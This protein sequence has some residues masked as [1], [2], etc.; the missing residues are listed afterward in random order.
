ML[1]FPPVAQAPTGANPLHNSV[2]VA[3][4]DGEGP[5]AKATPNVVVPVPPKPYLAV[6]TSATSVQL[7]PFHCSVLAT[8]LPLLPETANADVYIPNPA[9]LPLPVFKLFT[10]V[11]LAPFHT[12]VSAMLG[13]P[14]NFTAFDVVPAAANS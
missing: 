6:L 5:P 14:P 3:D 7:V 2:A 4:A 12:S 13:F 11:Q 1:A 8:L 9:N 10:S